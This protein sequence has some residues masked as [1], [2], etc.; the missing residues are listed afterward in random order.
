MKKTNFQI[1]Y[2]FGND[3]GIDEGKDGFSSIR[4]AYSSA[5]LNSKY[6]NL[7][8]EREGFIIVDNVHK[9]VVKKWGWICKDDFFRPDAGYEWKC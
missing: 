2:N 1:I 8:P 6:Y 9:I 4:K 5:L 7:N 3:G